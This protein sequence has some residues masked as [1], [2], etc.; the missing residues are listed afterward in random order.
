MS[1]SYEWRVIAAEGY[2][3]QVQEIADRMAYL[4]GLRHEMAARLDIGGMGGE[5][6]TSSVSGDSMERGTIR[7]IELSEEI[8]TAEAEYA[9]RMEE[10]EEVLARIPPADA[11]IIVLAYI[12]HRTGVSAAAELGISKAT[13]RTKKRTALARAYQ[14]L[15]ENAKRWAAPNAQPKEEI[16]LG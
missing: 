15:P 5:R 6:V 14:A 11:R 1:T 10:V 8:A 4:R 13:Y 16:W 7:L 12:Q 9:E 3:R 2:F